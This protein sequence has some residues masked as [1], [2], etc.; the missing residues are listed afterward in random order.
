MGSCNQASYSYTTAKQELESE[1]EQSASETC[2][3]KEAM[4]H[5]RH[6]S[7][8]TT[9]SHIESCANDVTKEV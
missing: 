4:Y 9:L 1:P 3:G 8:I 2:S 7:S 5:A 6:S